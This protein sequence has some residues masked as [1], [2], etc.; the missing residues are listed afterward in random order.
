V[1]AA[2][3]DNSPEPDAG[4]T[5][6]GSKIL[7]EEMG[8]W[9]RNDS[10]HLILL[11]TEHCNFRCTYC[12]EDFA[13]GRMSRSTIDGVKRLIDR[14]MDGLASLAIS[15]F[16]GE[17]LLAMPVIEE[18]SQHIV[19]Q[20]GTHPELDYSGSMTTNGY[21]LD[22]PMLER[23]V[24]LGIRSFQVSLDGPSAMHDRT[25][26][27]ADG[28]G[29]FLRIWGNLISIHEGSAP[30][31]M[32]VRVHLTPENLPL[33]PEFLT[34]IR[35]TFLHDSRFSVLL[36][37]VE[38]LGGPNDDTMM[39]V[40]ADDRDRIM[41]ELKNVLLQDAPDSRP[42][43]PAPDICYASR[44]NS[45]VIRANGNIGKC[46][47]GLT[48]PMNNIGHLSADGLLKIDNSLLRPWLRGWATLDSESLGCPYGGMLEARPKLVQLQP[49][50][51]PQ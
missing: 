7:A 44:P 42:L 28:S 49:A 43:F 15:W 45:F 21:F 12:Y 46:T 36:K 9:L 41:D 5:L 4:R 48:D 25:R 8:S 3:T 37:P 10:L 6:V 14:R 38:R 34:E 50:L 30:I 16:G 29:S 33:M 40:A 32:L 24:G 47:V 26:V 17:P 39:V 18:I 11:P 31:S 27:R 19:A 51:L 1:I 35:K 23:L 20:A 2:K 22:A 13:I